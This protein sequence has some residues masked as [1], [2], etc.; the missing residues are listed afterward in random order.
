M[1]SNFDMSGAAAMISWMQ[2]NTY[3]QACVPGPYHLLHPFLDQR[4][5][6]RAVPAQGNLPDDLPDYLVFVTRHSLL[7]FTTSLTDVSGEIHT[8]FAK[9]NYAFALDRMMRS[10]M[11]WGM[12]GAAKA[13][14]PLA[15]LQSW[16]PANPAP[17]LIPYFS[18]QQALP[19]PQ[20]LRPTNVSQD[21]GESVA[22]AYAAMMGFSAACFNAAPAAMDAWRTNV[23]G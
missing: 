10:F 14:E 7:A 1:F 15:V 2:G 17:K 16:F 5:R 6:R 12:P 18:G 9:L 22:T 8:F 21:V 13:S 23:A 19:T 4:V 20:S 11:L 3:A